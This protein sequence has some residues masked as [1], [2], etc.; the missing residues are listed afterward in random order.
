MEGY[1]FS[2]LTKDAQETAY[3]LYCAALDDDLNR[4][5]IISIE[6]YE[7]EAEYIEMLFDINGN[8]I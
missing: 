2:Q 8:A 3:A 1:K 4:D 6:D 7:A 5:D